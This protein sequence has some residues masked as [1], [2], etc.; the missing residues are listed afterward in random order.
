MLSVQLRFQPSS[1]AIDTATDTEVLL[2][3]PSNT[4]VAIAIIVYQLQH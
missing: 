4:S 3:Y 1:T 2:G